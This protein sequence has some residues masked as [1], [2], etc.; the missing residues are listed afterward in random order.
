MQPPRPIRG[1]RSPASR[2][3]PVIAGCIGKT[4]VGNGSGSIGKP[5]QRHVNA[6]TSGNLPNTGVS[7][8]GVLSVMALLSTA[9]VA[10]GR[11]ASFHERN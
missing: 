11:K 10:I 2:L 4:N 7:V 1:R 5:N 6:D 8:V 9:A 3:S